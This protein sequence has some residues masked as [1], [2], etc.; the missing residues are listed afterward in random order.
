MACFDDP[1][2]LAGDPDPGAEVENPAALADVACA[3]SSP[4]NYGVVP[5]HAIVCSVVSEFQEI[6]HVAMAPSE[7]EELA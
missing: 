5:G 3:F 7:A 1:H 6:D 4:G 2:P